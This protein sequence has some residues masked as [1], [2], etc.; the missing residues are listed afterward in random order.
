MKFILLI[1]SLLWSTPVFAQI[2]YNEDIQTIIE[3]TSIQFALPDDFELTQQENK[4]G[5]CYLYFEHPTNSTKVAYMIWGAT[6]YMRG[7]TNRKKKSAKEQKEVKENLFHI[8]NLYESTFRMTFIKNNN[9]TYRNIPPS[10]L[11]TKYVAD[12]G[13]ITNVFM[14]AEKDN[15]L[16]KFGFAIHKHDVAYIMVLL[17]GEDSNQVSQTAR[18]VIDMVAFTSRK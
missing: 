8:N 5:I 18:E 2:E 16:Y 9:V 17:T 13:S 12:W 4:D 11:T 15:H 3:R 1:V 6:N 10:L 14:G 7:L